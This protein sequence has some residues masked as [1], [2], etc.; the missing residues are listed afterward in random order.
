MYLTI[1]HVTFELFCRNQD[2]HPGPGWLLSADHKHVD[3]RL[4]RTRRLM[5]K[6]PETSPCY[7]I[8][9]QLEESA[10]AA[11]VA[12]AVAFKTLA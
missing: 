3:T 2:P 4:I 11:P 7:L 9:N 5:I 1:L 10:G 6:N 12:P 8:T